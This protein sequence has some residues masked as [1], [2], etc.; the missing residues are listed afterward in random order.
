MAV[1]KQSYNRIMNTSLL[2]VAAAV[3]A[4]VAG[5]FTIYHI[6]IEK[7]QVLILLWQSRQR[8]EPVPCMSCSLPKPTKLQALE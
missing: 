2:F 1:Q 6:N 4:V 8:Q 3:A 5:P 7:Q